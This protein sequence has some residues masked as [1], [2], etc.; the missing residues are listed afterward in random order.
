MTDPELTRCMQTRQTGAEH[1]VCTDC[2][3]FHSTVQVHVGLMALALLSIKWSDD[4][5]YCTWGTLV[6]Y[7]IV[8]LATVLPTRK[9][10]PCHPRLH[11]D[12]FDIGR[13][14]VETMTA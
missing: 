13:Y 3:P 4:R 8:I 6:R 10:I 2:R 11:K 1:E 7:Q 14:L 12:T 9:R 5:R